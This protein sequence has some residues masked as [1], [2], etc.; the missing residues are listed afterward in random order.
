MLSHT[1]NRFLATS[2]L[3]HGKKCNKN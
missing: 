3:Y 1:Y 2:R